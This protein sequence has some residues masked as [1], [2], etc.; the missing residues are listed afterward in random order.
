MPRKP[1]IKPWRLS[2]SGASTCR[3]LKHSFRT[4]YCVHTVYILKISKDLGKPRKIQPS[5]ASSTLISLIWCRWLL[6]NCEVA[7]WRIRNI[8][9]RN[10][11][12]LAAATPDE[13][14]NWGTNV[15]MFLKRV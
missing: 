11:K 5:I 14:F 12:L 6:G 1:T 7:G 8:R 3:R 13:F 15:A 4:T 2:A 9:N 10:M